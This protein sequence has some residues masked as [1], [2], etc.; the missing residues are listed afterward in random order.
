MILGGG[1][2]IL[3][4]VLLYINLLMV[5]TINVLNTNPYRVEYVI[6]HYHQVRLKPFVVPM[7]DIHIMLLNS[8]KMLS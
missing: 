5:D 6:I 4:V 8:V 7:N 1:G 2:P 3:R